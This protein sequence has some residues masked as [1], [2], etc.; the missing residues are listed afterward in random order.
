MQILA[1]AR[2]RRHEGVWTVPVRIGTLR[3]RGGVSVL[4]LRSP[5]IT[6]GAGSST[7]RVPPALSRRLGSESPASLSSGCGRGGCGQWAPSPHSARMSPAVGPARTPSS[8]RAGRMT[9]ELSSY[10]LERP[11]LPSARPSAVRLRYLPYNRKNGRL[12]FTSLPGLINALRAHNAKS[13]AGC[14]I[15]IPLLRCPAFGGS[16][17]SSTDAALFL[18]IWDVHG[19]GREVE[20]KNKWTAEISSLA[21][22]R[23][24]NT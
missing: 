6:S 21:L 18:N 15:F 13:N 7:Q 4:L 5:L 8:V 23:F 9:P 1:A 16:S 11:V 10:L 3:A 2:A 14:T 22:F 17:N 19:I 20:C 12:A 24:G